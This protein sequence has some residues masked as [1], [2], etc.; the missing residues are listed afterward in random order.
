MIGTLN[1]AWLWS[2][3]T[4]APDTIDY[5]IRRILGPSN[6]GKDVQATSFSLL[7][8]LNTHFPDGETVADYGVNL[9]WSCRGITRGNRNPA[10]TARRGAARVA[11]RD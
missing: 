1:A 10:A 7:E 6:D 2:M 3:T 5:D 11:G 8:T 4:T 9:T